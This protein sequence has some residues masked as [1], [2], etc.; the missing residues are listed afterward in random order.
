[1]EQRDDIE[2]L[3][4]HTLE[5]ADRAM[6]RLRERMASLAA[7]DTQAGINGLDRNGPLK[8]GERYKIVVE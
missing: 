4:E 6:A 7:G 8:P 2:Q 5:V 1:M 3:I